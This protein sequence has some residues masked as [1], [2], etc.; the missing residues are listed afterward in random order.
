MEEKKIEYSECWYCHKETMKVRDQGDC[1]QCT[2]C[3]ATQNM[4]KRKMKRGKKGQATET[5]VPDTRQYFP[6]SKRKLT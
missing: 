1:L 5:A 4:P 6:P 2:S 3:G